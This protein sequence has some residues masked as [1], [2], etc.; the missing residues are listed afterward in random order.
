M[1]CKIACSVCFL[2][3]AALFM[4]SKLCKLC[5]PY[6]A[7]FTKSFA[8]TAVITTKP[9]PLKKLPTPASNPL[10]N[11]FPSC[12]PSPNKLF[13]QSATP[14]TPS[15][16]LFYPREQAQC[17]PIFLASSCIATPVSVASAAIVD[18]SCSFFLLD[19]S[20]ALDC[21]FSCLS[22]YAIR[23]TKVSHS[24]LEHVDLKYSG[25]ILSNVRSLRIS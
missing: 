21:Y 8:T 19:S 12:S 1:T 24:S 25:N 16:I 23:L 2:E 11:R 7:A 15:R 9:G 5:T 13:A 10:A 3:R 14:L 20:V 17:L 4:P 6:F 22:S 18:L